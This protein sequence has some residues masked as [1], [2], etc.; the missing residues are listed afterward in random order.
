MPDLVKTGTP[1][2]EGYQRARRTF[3]MLLSN[4]GQSM[5]FSRHVGGCT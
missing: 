1:D 4:Y 5:H 2:G 3:G